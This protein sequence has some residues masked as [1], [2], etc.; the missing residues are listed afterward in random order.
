MTCTCLLVKQ[1]ARTYTFPNHLGCMTNHICPV[2]SDGFNTNRTSQRSLLIRDIQVILILS[3]RYTRRSPV[4]RHPIA[5]LC[6]L[7]SLRNGVGTICKLLYRMASV[8]AR[9]KDSGKGRK[10]DAA[11][12]RNQ[13]GYNS[14]ISV[15]IS[16]STHTYHLPD[17][18]IQDNEATF[19]SLAWR[20]FVTGISRTVAT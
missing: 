18:N 9:D 14:N 2:P 4:P 20:R 5:F 17:L 6:C 8:D 10:E 3:L 7:G 11:S 1:V 12:P 13:R 16:G 15:G 19:N